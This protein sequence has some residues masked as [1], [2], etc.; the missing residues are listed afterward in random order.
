[1]ETFLRSNRREVE[2][3]TVNRPFPAFTALL[4]LLTLAVLALSATTRSTSVSPTRMPAATAIQQRSLGSGNYVILVPAPPNAADEAL[5]EAIHYY[6]VTTTTVRKITRRLEPVVVELSGQVPNT[7]AAPSPMDCRSHYDPAYDA[8]IYGP[9]AHEK[10]TVL[11]ATH[12]ISSDEMLLIF[13]QLGPAS[14]WS[15]EFRFAA[16]PWLRTT[17]TRACSTTAAAR[18]WLV[19]HLQRLTSELPLFSHDAAQI[20]DGLG[21]S[22]IAS[23]EIAWSEYAELA[24]DAI[25][26]RTGLDRPIAGLRRTDVRFGDS[27][28][29]SAAP[30]FSVSSGLIVAPAGRLVP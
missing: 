20:P 26:S 23:S 4:A 6:P 21:R 10:P 27:L 5:S 22:E 28:R 14:R 11:H 16:G 3:T 30:Q 8:L 29:Y 19:F 2:S 13:Q 25:I 12:A 15:S 17:W 1:M 9:Q 24:D 18:L 7:S